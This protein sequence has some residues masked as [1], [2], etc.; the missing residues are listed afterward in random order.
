MV[1]F[2]CFEV[3][4]SASPFAELLL[5]LFQSWFLNIAASSIDISMEA[6]SQPAVWKKFNHL[7]PWG[8]IWCW[9]V[10]IEVV[11]STHSNV[12]KP[13]NNEEDELKIVFI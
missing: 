1:H 5:L 11:L 12:R 6:C 3:Q 13:A 4:S 9:I 2:C 8:F 10:G 7:S